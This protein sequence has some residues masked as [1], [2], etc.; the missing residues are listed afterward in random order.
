MLRKEI[1]VDYSVA[2]VDPQDLQA[3]FLMTPY[4]YRTARNKAEQLKER[5]FDTMRLQF[6]MEIWQK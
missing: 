6:H 3:L 2:I 5:Q 1:M 4:V